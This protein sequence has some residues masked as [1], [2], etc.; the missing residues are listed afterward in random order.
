MWSFVIDNFNNLCFLARK[1]GLENLIKLKS[2]SKCGGK[3]H[4]FFQI[5]TEYSLFIFI[6]GILARFCTQKMLLPRYRV[7]G[8][9]QNQHLIILAL[10]P[11]QIF[12]FCQNWKSKTQK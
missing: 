8:F 1:T 12:T 4:D 6:F 10:F 5:M 11:W 3:N 9:R 2:E 7:L